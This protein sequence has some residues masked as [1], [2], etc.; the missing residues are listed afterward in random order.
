MSGAASFVEMA[1]GVALYSERGELRL[2]NGTVLRA[3]QRYLYEPLEDGFVV[4]FCETGME[5]QRVKLEP[6]EDGAWV[7]SGEHLCGADHYATEYRF[8][9]GRFVVRHT[10]RGPRKDYVIRTMY[11]R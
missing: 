9:D 8:G 1:D 2:T 7:G 6:G 5:F 10:V 3:G 11:A 4:L